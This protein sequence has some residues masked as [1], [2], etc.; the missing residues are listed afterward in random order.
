MPRH[1]EITMDATGLVVQPGQGAVW[2]MSP[3]RSAA[4]KLQDAETAESVMAFVETAPA[5]TE[6]TSPPLR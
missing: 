6:T 5:G 4:L 2:N 3:G 1:K